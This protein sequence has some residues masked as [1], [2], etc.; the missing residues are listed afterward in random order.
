VTL[1]DWLDAAQKDA[2]RR[3]LPALRPLLKGLARSTAV[4]RAAEWNDDARAT[5]APNRSDAR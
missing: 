1:A 3:G 2:D 4:L 5:V